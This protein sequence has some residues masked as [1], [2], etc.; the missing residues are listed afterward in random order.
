MIWLAIDRC[1]LR[2]RVILF[3]SG[4]SELLLDIYGDKGPI[5]AMLLGELVLLLFAFYLKGRF[6]TI[7]KIITIAVVNDTGHFDMRLEILI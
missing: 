7:L 6:M 4:R 1:E 2:N 3:T 5:W